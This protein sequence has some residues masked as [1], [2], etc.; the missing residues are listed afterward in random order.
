MK[1]EMRSVTILLS[2]SLLLISVLPA[3][4]LNEPRQEDDDPRL[5]R[6]LCYNIHHGEGVDRKLD[7]SRIAELVQEIDPDIVALQE[8]DNEAR[9]S[10]G[11]D[12]ASELAK[13]TGMQVVFGKNIELQ[14]GGYGNAI[15]SKHE[16]AS[17]SNQH[18]PLLD[19][20]EQRGLLVAEIKL[21]SQTTPLYFLATHLDHRRPDEER[22][23]SAETIVN[24]A[25]EHP[26]HVA[27]LAGDM[28][29]VRGSRVLDKLSEA[30]TIAG[31]KEQPTVPVDAP[32]R[33]I[34]FV[35]GRKGQWRTVSSKVLDEAVASDHRAIVVVLERT[36]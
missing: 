4:A 34:D 2:L 21:P 23:Q 36:E 29:D 8:V 17:S 25:K 11:V 32:T 18:L 5:V 15:L 33:Q 22:F 12:Q 35:L 30:W 16:I 31:E 24:W 9:R 13:L 27:I 1:V 7:L 14:G 26:D 6:I 19:D 28:N 20:G 3:V 10:G